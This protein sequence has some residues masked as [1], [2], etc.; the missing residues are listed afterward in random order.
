MR[1]DLKVQF[2]FPKRDKDGNPVGPQNFIKITGYEDKVLAA[3]KVMQ[4]KIDTLNALSTKEID[5]D[6]RIHA[7]IIGGKGADIKELQDSFKVKINFPK[8]KDSNI[9]TITGASEDVEEA[10]EEI[11]ARAEEFVSPLSQ[12]NTTQT[13][14]SL[15]PYP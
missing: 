1:D 3:Q 13:T 5:V 8:N 14:F 7:R 12:P 15:P 6:S 11:L 9:I 4:E 10:A 2:D